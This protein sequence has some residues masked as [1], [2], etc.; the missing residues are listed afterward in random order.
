M[1]DVV[2]NNLLYLIYTTPLPIKSLGDGRHETLFTTLHEH[3]S[4]YISEAA[5]D[6]LFQM[7][8]KKRVNG[9]FARMI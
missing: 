4:F 7:L 3:Y 8:E 2:Q 1:T 9:E 5:Y 6:V